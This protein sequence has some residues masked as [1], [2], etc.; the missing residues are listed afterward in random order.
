MP[1]CGAANIKCYNE[2]EDDLLKQ[3]FMEGLSKTVE[4]KGCNCLPACT[5]IT[6]DA[7]I[8]QA[9]FD[10]VSLFNAYKNPLDEFP[11]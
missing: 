9:R 8:S 10:W 1:I 5:S 7:E 11:G 6:Y 4:K 2:A 3:D